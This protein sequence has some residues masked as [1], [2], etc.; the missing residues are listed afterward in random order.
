VEAHRW[1]EK[2]AALGDAVAMNNLGVLYN[3]GRGVSRDYAEARRWY[4]KAAALGNEL[5]KTNLATLR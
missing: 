3:T 1:Y 4:E 5:A 2:A